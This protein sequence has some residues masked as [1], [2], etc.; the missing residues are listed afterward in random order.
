MYSLKLKKNTIY[1]GD[2]IL[3]NSTY[4]YHEINEYS[5]NSVSVGDNIFLNNNVAI[6]LAKIMLAINAFDKISFVSGLRSNVEQSE[7]YNK[8]LL[9]NGEDFTKKYVAL[10]NHSE[11]QTGMAIDLGVK[12]ENI[13][14][15]CP[16]FLDTGICKEFLNNCHNYG[17][18]RRYPQD[19]EMITLIAYEPWHFR[20]VG[21]PH[22][23]II[24][25]L[26]ITLEEYHNLIQK[27]SYNANNY[28]YKSCNLIFEIGYLKA[29]DLAYTQIDVENKD[30]FS[31]SGDNQNGFIVTK[32]R[33]FNEK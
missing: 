24:K 10:P 3:V 7:I 2:L 25:K 14:F 30:C 31:I 13:D 21:Y 33:E 15:L 16:Q 1:R 8:S 20:Y 9:E 17:F 12:K 19:K 22:S 23:S 27:Y 6:A 18:I 28:I 4:A 5:N 26:K 11:H 32:W 29:S